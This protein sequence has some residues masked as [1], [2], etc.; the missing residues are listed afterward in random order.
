MS[1]IRGCFVVL[2][3]LLAF[4]NLTAQ[5]PG[6]LNRL[7]T[8]IAESLHYPSVQAK[9]RNNDELTVTVLSRIPEG[10]PPGNQL[11]VARELGAFIRDRL[12]ASANLKLINVVFRSTDVPGVA[13]ALAVVF[14]PVQLTPGDTTNVMVFTS[15]QRR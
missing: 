11:K 2:P 13:T 3:I 5:S 14:R 7:C 4:R 10:S 6:D 9:L 1:R 8:A 12:P 15:E